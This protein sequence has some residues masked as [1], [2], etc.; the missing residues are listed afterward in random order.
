MVSQ[1]VHVHLEPEL[2]VFPILVAAPPLQVYVYLPV[3]PLSQSISTLLKVG[4]TDLLT[5]PV[6]LMVQLAWQALLSFP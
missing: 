5:T 6:S 3:K 2:Q 1:L 4:L